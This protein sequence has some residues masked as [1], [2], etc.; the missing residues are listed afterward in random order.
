MAINRHK[1][2]PCTNRTVNQSYLATKELVV[3]ILLGPLFQ[4]LRDKTMDDKL[5]D[6]L[7]FRFLSFQMRERV[8]RRF[9]YQLN[10]QA[11]IAE[12]TLCQ[13]IKSPEFKPTSFK[14]N[15]GYQHNLLSEIAFPPDPY[16]VIAIKIGNSIWQPWFYGNQLSVKVKRY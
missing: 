5:T 15:F 11:S 3:I 6:T 10:L 1:T 9:G 7:T 4:L 2:L 14:K 12:Y 13:S 16:N 8:S